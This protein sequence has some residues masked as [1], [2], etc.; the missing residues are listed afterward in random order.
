MSAGPAIVPLLILY[1]YPPARRWVRR[2]YSRYADVRIQAGPGGLEVPNQMPLRAH[3]EIE[4][5]VVNRKRTGR[6]LQ[7][8]VLV[9][10]VDGGEDAFYVSEVSKKEA[11]E[12]ETFLREQVG[13]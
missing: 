3:G 6:R 2:E 1:A 12:I 7:L 4:G 13:R 5:I 9:E 8:E 11:D 10:R